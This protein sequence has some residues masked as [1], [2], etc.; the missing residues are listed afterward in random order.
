MNICIVQM[1][2]IPGKPDLNF[3][4]IKKEVKNAVANQSDLV[5][6]PEMC[7][8]GILVGNYFENAS[9]LARCVDFGNQ[10]VALSNSIDILFGNVA[11]EAGVGDCDRALLYNA[12]FYASGGALEPLVVC[13]KVIKCFLPK[14]L[15]PC[16]RQFDERYYF[17]DMQELSYSLNQSLELLLTPYTTKKGIRIGLSIGEDILAA[18]MSECDLFIN[19]S[20]MPYEMGKQKERHTIFSGHAKRHKIPLIYVNAVGTQNNGKNIYAFEG[21]SSIYDPCGNLVFEESAFKSCTTTVGWQNKKVT[22]AKEQH[23]SLSEMAKVRSAL[24]YMIAENLRR[25]GIERVV[26]GAS[27]GIDSAVCAALYTEALGADNVFLV[28]MPTCFNSSTTRQAA[29]DLATNLGTP[30]LEVPITESLG[31]FCKSLALLSFDGNKTPLKVEGINHENL[32]ARTRSTIF[33]ATIASVLNAAFTCNGNKSEVM[34]GYCTLYGDTSG[35]F[36]AI[37]DLW[38]TQVYELALEINR[39]KVLIPLA[40][41]EVPASAELS[42]LQNVDEGKGDPIN[43][44]YHDKLFSFW[45]ERKAQYSLADS[46]AALVDGTLFEKLGV[47]ELEFRL[48]FKTNEEAVNDMTYWWNRYKGIGVGKRVQMPP[49]LSV[50]CRAFGFDLRESQI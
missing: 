27:G 11:V 23:E 7:L 24:V 13:E 25:F 44:Q 37:G 15:L 47:S 20:S 43:Y 3:E 34:V 39:E 6:F 8:S 36:C 50:S 48:W 33:L 45:M 18:P 4:T 21:G 1:N 40:S 35:I 16:S 26:I 10:V 41:I 49:I 17:S 42:E 2:V 12:A 19:I 29:K 28:S 5:V 14:I 38:K 32:Q 31:V 9:F 30:Y 22:V 46:I